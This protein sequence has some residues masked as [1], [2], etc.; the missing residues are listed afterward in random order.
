MDRLTTTALIKLPLV[1]IRFSNILLKVLLSALLLQ[2]PAL[3]VRAAD[4]QSN[5]RDQLARSSVA[6]ILD[7]LVNAT[8]FKDE[9][10]S[11]PP[12]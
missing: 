3:L 8:Y 4:S 10:F 5:S 2:F 9:H 7:S 6:E 1:K 12:R 11:I